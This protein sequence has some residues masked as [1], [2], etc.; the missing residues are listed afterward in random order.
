MVYEPSDDTFLMLDTIDQ[1][2]STIAQCQP[3]VVVEIGSGSGC[4][5][6]GL[7]QALVRHAD[8]ITPCRPNFFASDISA[9]AN[10]ATAQTASANGIIVEV[11]QMH[12]L[13]AMRPGTIDVLLFNP[14]YVPTS[15]DEAERGQSTH[16]ISATWA[17][18]PRGRLVLDRLLPRLGHLLSPRGRFYLLGVRENDPSDVCVVLQSMGF[19]C[20][21]VMERRAQNERLFVLE[22]T[23]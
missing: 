13:D 17:G 18:G 8:R 4:L 23:R 22:A 21:I 11:M 6:V 1:E 20:R 7:A 10:A 16:D 14:P 12:L 9:A 15:A 3:S 19:S 5:I 2:A